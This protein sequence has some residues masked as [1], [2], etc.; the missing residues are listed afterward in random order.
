M[1]NYI[2]NDLD[3]NTMNGGR[4]ARNDVFTFA[5]QAGHLR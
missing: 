3:D 4:K 5:K 2:I 1:K